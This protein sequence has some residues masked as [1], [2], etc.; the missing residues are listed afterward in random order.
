MAKEI[1][2][3][4]GKN[5]NHIVKIDNRLLDDAFPTFTKDWSAFDLDWW[6][7]VDSQVVDKRDNVIK[8]PAMQVKDLMHIR[9]HMTVAG[10]IKRSNES[11]KKLLTVQLSVERQEKDKMIYINTNIFDTSYIDS[12]YNVWIKIKPDVIG[13][14]NDIAMWTRFALEQVTRLHTTYAKKLFMFLKQWRTVGSR[15]FT[16]DEFREKLAV[17]KSYKPGSIDQKIL[18]PAAEELAPYFFNFRIK[19]NYDK[20]RRG[21]KLISYTF[22]FKPETKT[23]KEIGHSK[24]LE[25]T[26]HIYSIMSNDYLTAEQRFRAVDRYR[27]LT[28]G[29]TQKY[30]EESHPLTYFINSEDGSRS[31]RSLLHRSDLEGLSGYSITILENLTYT[32]E[33]LLGDGKLR[34]WDIQDLSMIERQLLIKQVTL[35]QKTKDSDKPYIPKRKSIAMH[36]FHELAD[37]HRLDDYDLDVVKQEIEDRIRNEFG[38]NVRSQDNRNLE[39]KM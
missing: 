21:R 3:E 22:T 34:E 28:F 25:E 23:Q 32:Y 18:N 7:L 15:T 31:K 29:T 37:K 14:F 16:I 1:L 6:N 27:G 11:L 8:I 38:K 26:Q 13:Y 24:V 33:K 4:E 39:F 9:K 20:G 2:I 12:D 17:P 36:L 35:S 5:L 30:Y 10:F 19:K